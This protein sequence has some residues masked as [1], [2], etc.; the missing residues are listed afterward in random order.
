MSLSIDS[1]SHSSSNGSAFEDA[2]C[3]ALSVNVFA[4]TERVFAFAAPITKK[5]VFIWMANVCRAAVSDFTPLER[6]QFSENWF[7][8]LYAQG[9]NRVLD[10]YPTHRTIDEIRAALHKEGE[11]IQSTHYEFGPAY[12]RLEIQFEIVK[13]LMKMHLKADAVR[14]KLDDATYRGAISQDGVNDLNEIIQQFTF[15]DYELFIAAFHGNF[16][17][18]NLSAQH[19]DCRDTFEQYRKHGRQY[20]VDAPQPPYNSGFEEED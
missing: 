3:E 1:F 10:W 5:N 8:D 20:R 13:A 19:I 18:S 17:A 6:D 15:S 4:S 16:D 11:T 14:A 7:S 9:A 12:G 2:V